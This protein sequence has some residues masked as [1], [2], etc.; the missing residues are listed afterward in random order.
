MDTNIDTG[1]RTT[2]EIL[3]AEGIASGARSGRKLD[4]MNLFESH[5]VLPCDPRARFG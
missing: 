3:M 1:S 2:S 5:V 4:A